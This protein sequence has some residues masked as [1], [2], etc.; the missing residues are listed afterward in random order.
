LNHQFNDVYGVRIPIPALQRGWLHSRMLT[1]P[2]NIERIVEKIG[3]RC[4]FSRY[5]HD[6]RDA[7]P[8]K[9]II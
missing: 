4:W 9:P 1:L 5:H 7:D 3:D 6:I 8:K 2:W